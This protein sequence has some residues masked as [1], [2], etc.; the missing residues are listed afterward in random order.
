M[1]ALLEGT[2]VE[3]AP[4]SAVISAAGVGYAI[5]IPLSTF[6]TLPL[7]GE[8]ARVFTYLH[9][10]E[11]ALQLFGFGTREERST[12]EKMIAISGV[13]PKLALSILSSMPPSELVVAI[14]TGQTGTLNKIS[15]VG[16]KTAE[17]LVLEL[18]GKLGEVDVSA[19]AVENGGP[20]RNE[21]A[22]AALISLGFSRV[23]AEK[24]V[25]KAAGKTG[26]E[27]NTSDLVRRALA[28]M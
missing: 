20:P 9:V 10:R 25:V 3:K 2:L 12:F 19:L 24:A 26:E 8:V 18:K 14:E 5:S 27:F 1:I 28:S 11:D 15:G 16:K 23:L 6:D 7:T 22:V 21:E 13:G 4:G 17:R